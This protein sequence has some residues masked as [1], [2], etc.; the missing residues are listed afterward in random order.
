[1]C[2]FL[3]AIAT[4]DGRLLFTECDSHEVIIQ[5]AGLRDESL[6]L[7]HWVRIEQTIYD[8]KLRVDE[9]ECP[10]WFDPLEWQERVTQL[11]AQVR[12]ARE[13]FDIAVAP[14]P[15]YALLQSIAVQ[16]A[17][18]VLCTTLAGIEG[19]CPPKCPPKYDESC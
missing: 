5:R 9:T 4:R 6:F 3:S 1:M 10:S 8:R 19:Y 13:A 15:T 18:H 12:P 17:R 2:Q 11:L 16:R 14:R 7:R